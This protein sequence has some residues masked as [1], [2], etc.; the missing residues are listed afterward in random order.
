MIPVY[1]GN[2]KIDIYILFAGFKFS[3]KRPYP[4]S[5]IYDDLFSVI[6]TYLYASGPSPMD[7]VIFSCYR[8][9][10]PRTPKLDFHILVL[11]KDRG[12][13]SLKAWHRD[14]SLLLL[15]ISR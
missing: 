6:E 3:A 1:V 7:N 11:K 12:L 9:R 5:S 2:K 8:D 10:S 4:C 13:R 15:G 14:D